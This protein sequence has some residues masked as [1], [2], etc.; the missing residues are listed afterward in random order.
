LPGWGPQ[1]EEK[2][3]GTLVQEVIEKPNPD[4]TLGM[5]HATY[6]KVQP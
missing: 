3:Q 4:I 1:A 5:R 6:E 2:K